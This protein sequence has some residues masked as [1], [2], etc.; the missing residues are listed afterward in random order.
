MVV[1]TANHAL[2]AVG[3]AEATQHLPSRPI[4]VCGIGDGAT[5]QGE[6]LEAVAQAVRERL[7]VLFLVED[8]RY[9]IS[10]TTQGRTFFSLPGGPAS[11][12][13]GERIQRIDGRDVVQAHEQLG[14]IVAEMRNR[15]GP[16]VVVLEV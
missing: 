7:P 9:A 14:A 6:F 2:Q 4:V 15:R 8:N 3:V 12:Y 11:E 10:T 13:L 16:A 5:Q 1:P